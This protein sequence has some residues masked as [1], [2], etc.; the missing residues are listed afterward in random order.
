M[1][2]ARKSHAT[3]KET[4]KPSKG[5]EPAF[6]SKV[7]GN[8][9]VVYCD[10]ER[11]GDPYAR[12]LVLNFQAKYAA[13]WFIMK[14]IHNDEW[15]WVDP[16]GS[17]KCI[18]TSSGI[19]ISMFHDDLKM[20]LEYKPTEAEAAWEDE[21]TERSVLRFKYGQH[22]EVKSR[23]DVE[24]DQ[25]GHDSDGGTK[26]TK[27]KGKGPRAPKEPKVK[28]DKSGHISAN[29]IAKELKLEGRE[30]RG[31]LRASKMQKPAHGWS[32]IKGSDEYKAARKTIEDGVKALKKKKGKK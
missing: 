4:V 5:L 20:L 7:G 6:A 16:I 18:R 19:R 13:R 10:L 12:V 29:D 24:E 32:W 27:S 1:A 26:K 14:L 31:I 21:W 15:Q 11:E 30:I 25:D 17:R 8:K 2:R 9:Y 3:D 28:V 22:E 23:H